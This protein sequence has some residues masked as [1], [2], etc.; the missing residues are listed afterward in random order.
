MGVVKSLNIFMKVVQLTISFVSFFYTLRFCSRNYQSLNKFF[1]MRKSLNAAGRLTRTGG[2]EY[3]VICYGVTL[4]PMK[5]IHVKCM[6][7]V[8]TDGTDGALPILENEF[9]SFEFQFR[10]LSDRFA[11]TRF[12]W[13]GFFHVTFLQ[14]F[15]K[16]ISE[17]SFIDGIGSVTL[18][19]L[20]HVDIGER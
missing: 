7:T 8:G 15:N 4:S 19:S 16:T 11:V 20:Q 6:L 9:G 13:H 5:I 18:L 3:Q 10:D 2:V 12:L 14:F 1:I 17:E